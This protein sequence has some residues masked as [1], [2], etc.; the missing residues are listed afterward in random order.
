MFESISRWLRGSKGSKDIGKSRLQLI[1]AYERTEI[2]PEI[3]DALKEEIFN[4]I[5]KYF[6]IKEDDVE[7]NIAKTD[8]SVALMANIPIL[9]MKRQ[10][11]Q[12]Q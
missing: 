4:T 9:S 2:H 8:E 11:T 5:S 3:L 10:T 1:L 6:I 12:T 7:M